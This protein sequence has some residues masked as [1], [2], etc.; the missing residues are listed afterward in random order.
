LLLHAQVILGSSIDEA[1]SWSQ[2]QGNLPPA[3]AQLISAA[4][5]AKGEPF[6]SE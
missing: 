2:Q 6:N 3:E 4:L 5:A 1:L